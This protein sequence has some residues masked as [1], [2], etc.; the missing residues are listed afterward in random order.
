MKIHHSII[1]LAALFFSYAAAYGGG[2]L[3]SFDGRAVVYQNMPIPY[4]VDKGPLGTLSNDQATALVDSCFLTWQ[5]VPTAQ[6][7]FQNKGSLPEDVNGANYASYFDNADA[8]MNPVLFDSDGAIVDSFF[9]AGASTSVIGFSGSEYDEVTGYYTG[10]ISLLNGR[11]ST[12][13][14]YDQF[15]ATFVHEFG[16][17]FGLDHCQINGQYAGDGNTANDIYIPTM[18]PT[19]TDDDLSLGSLNPD[20][21]A[22][23]TLLYP[24]ADSIVLAAYGKIQGTVKWRNGKP[25]LGANVVAVKTGD[26]N[27]A[28]FSSVS[29]YYQEQT[30]AFEMLATPGSYKIF[31]EPINKAFT[32][33]SSVGPYAQS[34]LSPSFTR[35]VSTQYYE[36]EVLVAAGA[37]ASGIDF[38][39]PHAPPC[40]AAAILG[41]HSAEAAVLRKFRDTL[42]SSTVSGREY[43]GLY[44]THADEMLSILRAH[45]EIKRECK[46]IL[47][48]LI[49]AIR[50]AV[51][52]G[53]SS[54]SKSMVGDIERLCDRMCEKATPALQRAIGTVKKQLGVNH[55]KI[56]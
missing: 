1:A 55:G 3:N 4:A 35:P 51:N 37:T 28:Q 53:N 21:E 8:G 41:E 34:L 19:A 39:A 29:D 40:P 12:V 50:L 20:D 13:F 46:K 44:Y 16:H 24:A 22:A 30:G 54:L 11:F 56:L 26:E 52:T 49:P 15:K 18:Y 36:S 6:I 5:S 10:G 25:V 2:P 32:G 9:G 43:A 14:S 17:F 47:L 45:A 31:I 42:L 38:I 48:A 7:S 23:V 33:G 27:M